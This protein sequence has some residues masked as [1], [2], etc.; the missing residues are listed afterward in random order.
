MIEYRQLKTGVC[1]YNVMNYSFQYGTRLINYRLIKS[2]RKTLGITVYP[3][4]KIIVRAPLLKSDNDIKEKIEKKAKW[5]TKQLDHLDSL[6]DLLKPKLFISGE[7]HRYLGKQYRLKI[8]K[9]K[10]KKVSMKGGYI[11]IL[12]P[13]TENKK[14]VE[15]LLDNWYRER[16]KKRFAIYLDEC[17][18]L[19][20]KYD[21]VFPM[22]YI[23]KMK[24]RW[25]S[26][27]SSGRITL[28][29]DLIKHP[30]LSI[31]Y[32]IIH[33]LCHLKYHGHNKDFYQFLTKVMP[34]WEKQRYKLNQTEI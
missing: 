15:T 1:R 10:N 24:T 12:L 9:D 17:F 11:H 2:K 16:A 25:G 14:Q 32:V 6:P 5:I 20:K 4:K 13:D 31:R 8:I 23:R 29:L 19:M 22:L 33:E 30:S 7:T 3:D 34:D 28:N 26:C 18:L 21:I 27:S